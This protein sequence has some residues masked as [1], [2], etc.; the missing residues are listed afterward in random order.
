MERPW[1]DILLDKIKELN[2]DPTTLKMDGDLSNI[3]QTV[4]DYDDGTYSNVS[5]D[6]VAY[7]N[8]YVYVNEYCQDDSY[9]KINVVRKNPTAGAWNYD[10]IMN[11]KD[12]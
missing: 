4:T 6:M 9:Q 2:E 10:E 11:S 12:K 5:L 1:L 7:T 8:N 3:H